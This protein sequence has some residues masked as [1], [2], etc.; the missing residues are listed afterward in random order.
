MATHVK[1]E[2]KFQR[3]ALSELCSELGLIVT[4][5]VAYRDCVV[6][7]NN[8]YLFR[9]VFHPKKNYFGV[10][11]AIGQTAV[12]RYTKETV[13]KLVERLIENRGTRKVT[14]TSDYSKENHII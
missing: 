12:Y 7:K 2:I 8:I 3:E 5:D 13:T 9:A 10:R 11:F 14:I 4:D 1:Q 6:K